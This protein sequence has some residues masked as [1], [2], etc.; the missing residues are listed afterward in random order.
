MRRVLQECGH[1]PSTSQLRDFLASLKSDHTRDN[2]VK[3]IKTYFRDFLGD[4][5]ANIFRLGSPDPSPPWC[6]SKKQVQE[7][8]NA[9]EG[10][11]EQALFLMYATSGRRKNEV[12]SLRLDD[13]DLEQRVI[14]PNKSSATKKTWHSFFNQEAQEALKEYLRVR[15]DPMGS[16]RLFVM[17]SENHYAMF[18][19]A[20]EKTG[21]PITPKPLRFWFANEMARLGVPDRFMMP[22][23]AGSR[24][25]SWPDTTPTTAS[26][27][28]KPYATRRS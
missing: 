12:L 7:F 23:R 2:Y 18:K 24:G 15:S 5:R 13:V 11:K 25:A 26:R 10:I 4:P 9:L 8:Y 28:S 1:N 19:I 20:R 22:S 27:G 6:P 3:A 21:L 16:E 17:S 14:R